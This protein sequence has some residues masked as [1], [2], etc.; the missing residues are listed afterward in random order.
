MSSLTGIFHPTPVP[1]ITH[2]SSIGECDT[3]GVSLLVH[4][5]RLVAKSN[6]FFDEDGGVAVKPLSA[7]AT[8]VH[9]EGNDFEGGGW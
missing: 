9:L 5:G 3:R 6:M 7:K 1:N 2:L 4:G 8:T